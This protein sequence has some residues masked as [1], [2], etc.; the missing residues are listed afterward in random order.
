[1]QATQAAPA[2]DSADLLGGRLGE[3]RYE[4]LLAE[5]DAAARLSGAAQEKVGGADLLLIR[6]EQTDEQRLRKAVHQRDG[7]RLGGHNS[8]DG[9]AVGP[10]VGVFKQFL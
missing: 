5:A 10:W 9:E 1:M 3:G 6:P 4:G 8:F 2:E 7:V